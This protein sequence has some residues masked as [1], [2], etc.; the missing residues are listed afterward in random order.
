MATFVLV[1]GAFH[2]AWLW[3]RILPLLSQAGHEVHRLDLTGQ[4]SR[5]HDA[6]PRTNLSTHVSDVVEY[7]DIEDIDDCILVGHSY[8]GMVI[9]GAAAALHDRVR[10]LVFADAMTPSLGQSAADFAGPAMAQAARDAAG[11]G[12]L[13]P[14]FL[15]LVKFGPFASPAEEAWFQ[16]KLR[17]HPVACFFE[18]LVEAP[19]AALR[20]SFIYSSAKP[21][22]IFDSAAEL[23]RT[24]LSWDYYQIESGHDAMLTSPDAFGAALLEIAD[25]SAL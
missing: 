16:A 22:G 21:L 13:T 11:D 3:K 18:P 17:P 12:W 1:A 24:S 8:S 25:R 14:F 7:V 20:K 4:G 9:T 15:P 2:G 5:F 6:N 19:S 23:A 10:Q